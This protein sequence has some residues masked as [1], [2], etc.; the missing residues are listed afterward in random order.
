MTFINWIR[1][2]VKPMTLAE[3]Q[4]VIAELTEA[5]SPGFDF[6]LL[7][8]LSGTIA[9]MG[10]IT[11]SAAVIIGAMLLAPLM[12]PIIGIGMASITGDSNKLKKSVSALLRGA[13]L[14]I[15]LS[16]LVTLV[17]SYMP[18][19]SLQELPQEVLSRTRPTPLDLGIALAGGIAAAYALTQPNLS[20][21]LPGVAIAT[22]LMPPLCTVGIGMAVGRWDVAGGA[23]LLFL[24]NAVTIA[25]AAVLVFFARGFSNYSALQNGRLPRSLL[26]SAV[27]TLL[28]LVPLTYYSLTFFRDAS[29]NRKIQEVVTRHVE[30]LET[31]DL[32]DMEVTRNGDALSMELTLQS[33]APIRYQDVVLLQ[34]AIVGELNRSVSLKVNQILAERLDPLV[35]PTPTP[36]LTPTRTSTPGPSPS[37]TPTFTSTA[38]ATATATLTPLPTSTPTVTPTP[39]LAR[40]IATRLPAM[41]IH[42]TP[43]G[44]V[45]GTLV[46]GQML[47]IL[48]GSEVVNGM[49]WQ[50]VL[51][52]EGRHGWVLAVYLHQVTLT[53][54]KTATQL[55]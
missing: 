53:P 6:F 15:A 50:E 3:K 19:I 24:T 18:I 21:A 45:I 13:A 29:E 54:T 55:P 2:W 37:P 12:S 28:L 16:F 34:E 47:T 40:I 5:A 10:L 35:P 1:Q 33:N 39:A 8:I 20:A 32:V 51:D 31:V 7:V 23:A 26:Y 49:Q 38:T 44:P 11:N 48:Y 14:A 27:F 22:A 4:A 25:F 17:N 46:P 43:G 36:T 9:T 52:E 30:G 41:S 42:Q